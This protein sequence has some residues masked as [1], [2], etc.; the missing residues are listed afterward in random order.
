LVS[1][2]GSI[3]WPPIAHLARLRNDTS[4]P[5]RVLDLATGGGDVPISLARLAARDGLKV[6]IDGCDKSPHAVSF[7]RSQAL[8]R[9][10]E[11]RYFVLD[12]LREPV[13]QGYDIVSCSLFLHHLGETEAIELL[14]R[15]AFSARCL[16]LVDDL[17]RSRFGYLLAMVG[18]HLLSRSRVVHVD[19]PISVAAAYTPDE[20]LSLAERAGLKG[21]VLTRHWPQRFLIAWS[22]T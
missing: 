1:R 6:Q 22:V 15:M 11:V 12:V 16:V 7:A 8:A 21:A 9:G 18:C 2:T 3:L 19:G 5:L 17:V 10:V 4:N 13:P 14:V 20:A